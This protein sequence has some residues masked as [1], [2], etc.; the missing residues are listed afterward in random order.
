MELIF[1]ICC[2]VAVFICL[3]AGIRF[4]KSYKKI[5]ILQFKNFSLAFLLISLAFMMLSLPNLILFNP[6][7]VQIDFI[8]VDLSLLGAEL[9]L[10]PATLSFL[11]PSARVQKIVLWAISS[12]LVIYVPLNIFFFAPAV[13]LFSDGIYYWKN[14]V[15]WLHSIV[16]VPLA[17]GG[18]LIG[19]WFLFATRKIKEK[20]LFWRS[21]FFGLTGISIFIA[22]ILFWYFKF[23][24]PSSKILTISGIIGD[25]GFLFGVIGAFL[26][27]PSRET[28]VKKI[29]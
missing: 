18:G 22:G 10:I 6:F 14:G 27:Q 13:H 20:K 29:T 16:W 3:S 23:F 9:F 17:S 8:L 24:N 26:Y 4:W 25:F 11:K 7:W 19:V 1:N 12:I 28:L 21:F 2:L 15:F 5:G